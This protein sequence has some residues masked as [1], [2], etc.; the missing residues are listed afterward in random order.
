MKICLFTECYYAGGMDTWIVNLVNHWPG[1]DEFCLVSN[2][3]HP[4]LDV[5]EKRLRKKC[6]II[7]HKSLTQPRLAMKFSGNRMLDILRKI[8]ISIGQYALLGR[9]V[10]YFN[11]LFRKI[12]PDKVVVVNGGYPGGNTCRAAAISGLFGNKWGR[13][14]MA[15][16]NDAKESKRSLALLEYIV[17]SMVGKSVS[18]LI[19]V[20]N[21]TQSTLNKRP[22][23]RRNGNR[24]V[25]YNGIE[26]P[27]KRAQGIGTLKDEFGITGDAKIL[28]M[29][30]SY[31]ERKGHEFLFKSLN[32]LIEK[33]E[34]QVH[35]IV[36]GH[37]N[38]NDA[39]RIHSLIEKQGLKDRIHLAGFRMDV[40]DMLSQ[41]DVLVVPSQREESFG[42]TIIEAM[43]QSVPVVATN[44][45]GIPEVLGKNKGG[46]VTEKDVDDFADK[47][48]TLLGEDKTREKIGSEGYAEYLKRFTADK[49]AKNYY[50]II[51]CGV[52]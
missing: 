44:V 24:K 13:P 16:H 50:E 3:D 40:A 25:I 29:L 33:G 7:K 9:H 32:K 21:H 43:S 31:E 26:S 49:M 45:G 46:F 28:L 15:Y 10:F 47:I 6:R 42:L 39:E 12:A 51:K 22:G 52:D 20:S 38:E 19:T 11:G 34:N 14:I 18:S 35:L 4:G 37:G 23:L 48:S 5:I 27:E 41:T 1:D 30:G 2:Y 8:F 36:A 17:D